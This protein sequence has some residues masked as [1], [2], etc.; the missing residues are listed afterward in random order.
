M[1]AGPRFGF[2]GSVAALVPEVGHVVADSARGEHEAWLARVERVPQVV[3]WDAFAPLAAEHAAD[4]RASPLFMVEDASLEAASAD[5]EAH[6]SAGD[7]AFVVRDGG[8][9]LAYL[10]VGPG[11]IE[12][13]LRAGTTMAQ[14][15]SAFVV[16]EARRSGIGGAL[17]QRA[18]DWAR[19][20][21]FGRLFVEHETAN[22]LGV[23]FWGA[24]L[25]VVRAVLHALRRTRCVGGAAGRRVLDA[26]G[27]IL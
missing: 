1:V 14:V 11:G 24:P 18:V 25:R 16:P 9:A 21:G 6:R 15:R 13:R 22:P 4:C 5:L 2:R 26:A 7:A 20:A 8:T 10:I 27:A 17:L 3:P 23:P 19:D 12:G